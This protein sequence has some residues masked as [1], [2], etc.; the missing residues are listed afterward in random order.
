[1]LSNA[2]IQKGLRRVKLVMFSTLL[3][4]SNALNI[5][6]LRLLAA[7]DYGVL[8]PPTVWLCLARVMA[9]CR[10][11]GAGAVDLLARAISAARL[12]LPAPALPPVAPHLLGRNGALMGI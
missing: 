8:E 7:F 6:G 9:T 5:K 3:V 1:M 12:G 11:R 2:L 10:L 4:L